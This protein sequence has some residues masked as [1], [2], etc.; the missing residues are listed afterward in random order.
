ME[1][2]TEVKSFGLCSFFKDAHFLVILCEYVPKLLS[3]CEMQNESH[4]L[5]AE[6]IWQQGVGTKDAA[7]KAVLLQRK[8]L[9]LE[10]GKQRA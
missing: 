2:L 8:A 7:L 10:M 4:E 3:C 9:R 5:A 6:D 1:D